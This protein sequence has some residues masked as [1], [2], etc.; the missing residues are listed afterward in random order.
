LARQQQSGV[1]TATTENFLGHSVGAIQTPKEHVHYYQ[2]QVQQQE[3]LLTEDGA[4]DYD[5]I[6]S[7]PSPTPVVSIKTA[8]I[9]NKSYDD[10]RLSCS[11]DNSRCSSRSSSYGRGDF[12]GAGADEIIAVNG[13][14]AG[15]A[16]RPRGLNFIRKLS[17]KKK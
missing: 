14:G 17:L 13:T 8:M 1:L 2:Q 12:E 15:G 16:K 5:S 6:H 10:S 4:Q 3:I 9:G 7:I 11:S